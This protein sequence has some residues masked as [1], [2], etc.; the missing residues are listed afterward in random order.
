[1]KRYLFVAAFFVFTVSMVL[2]SPFSAAGL[3]SAP[4]VP[5]EDTAF[6]QLFKDDVV[7][8]DDFAR[9]TFYTWTSP[10]Q[11]DSLRKGAPLMLKE[12]VS[13]QGEYSLY[14][15]ELR[16]PKYDRNPVAQLLRNPAFKRE[17]FAWTNPW[18]TL[19]DF[20]GEYYG[21]QLIEIVLEDSA[22]ICGFFPGSKTLFKVFT[23]KGEPVPLSIALKHPERWA[24]VYH[25]NKTNQRAWG[26][27]KYKGTRTLRGKRFTSYYEPFREYV[28][29]N[30][31]LV[32]MW[33]YS[34]P[35]AQGRLFKDIAK[36]A[37]LLPPGT[38]R[39]GSDPDF[40]SGYR[41]EEATKRW[42]KQHA[43]TGWEDDFWSSSA[44][45]VSAGLDLYNLKSI[46]DTL[47]QR[48]E[49]QHAHMVQFPSKKY[50]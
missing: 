35:G 2:T 19:S 21:D 16:D 27:R 25:V 48:I 37:A 9:N 39:S 50:R 7:F 45:A 43:S 31:R 1:M 5:D 47:K 13:A 12:G 11:I 3:H 10:R 38:A 26:M 33:D 36:F 18:A 8:H 4:A 24:A 34:G 20:S 29:I 23:V 6:A 42:K 15:A 17:R 40:D 22:Y 14:D 44:F 30:E 49:A 46:Q 28:L 32:K 41:G